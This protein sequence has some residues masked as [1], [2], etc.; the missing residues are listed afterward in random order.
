ML[1]HG[2]FHRLARCRNIAALPKLQAKRARTISL[3]SLP[4]DPPLG[5]IQRITLR[6]ELGGN[7]EI[8]LDPNSVS[9][10]DRF[11]DSQS[12]TTLFVP[13]VA[14]RFQLVEFPDPTGQRRKIYELIGKL[15]PPGAR[16]YLISPSRK[17]GIYRLVVDESAVKRRVIGLEPFPLPAVPAERVEKILKI[18]TVVLNSNPPTL[19]VTATGQ[20]NSAGWKNP[21]LSRRVYV[22]PPADGI[23][24]YDLLALP[25]EGAAATVLSELQAS[26]R[27]P[28]YDASVVKGVRVYGVGGGVK[29]VQLP[30][31]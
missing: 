24:E 5:Q 25:P 12:S 17:T 13:P 22:T 3:H 19:L 28:G 7:G 18:E 15:S 1:A 27:W 29:T 31:H 21:Q 30:A 20:V 11:G 9:K 23:W 10:P 6:G 14:V 2:L 4:L 26:N 16:Y 8:V